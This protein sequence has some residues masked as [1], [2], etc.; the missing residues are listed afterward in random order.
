MR[1]TI[2]LCAGTFSVSRV[3]FLEIGVA[4]HSGGGTC[5]CECQAVPWYLE[6]KAVASQGRA[7]EEVD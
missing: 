2:A 7:G 6:A 5:L 1:L 3:Q 4:S